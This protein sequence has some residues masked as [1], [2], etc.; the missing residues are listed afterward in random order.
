MSFVREQGEKGRKSA[1]YKQYMS[2]L[3]PF[4]TPLSRK[5]RFVQRSHGYSIEFGN[6]RMDVQCGRVEF[7][8]RRFRRAQ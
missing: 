3:R 6:F 7:H 1:V 2:I 8:V 5:D 4:S